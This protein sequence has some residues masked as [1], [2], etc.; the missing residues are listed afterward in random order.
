MIHFVRYVDGI[1]VIYKK[2][3]EMASEVYRDEI[4]F[5]I[6]FKIIQ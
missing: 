2:Y 3:T 1:V 5:E 6:Y 4:M